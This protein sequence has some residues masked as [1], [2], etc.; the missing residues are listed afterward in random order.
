[1]GK[2]G[3]PVLS[4]H[5][6]DYIIEQERRGRARTEEYRK[7]EGLVSLQ[8]EETFR[9][10]K[11][12]KREREPTPE[13]RKVSRRNRGL[14]GEKGGAAKSAKADTKG[15]LGGPPWGRREKQ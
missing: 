7:K 5:K 6:L 3:L 8:E 11:V 9:G 12:Y 4:Q 2:Q 13:E 15:I 14:P 1:L 10:R